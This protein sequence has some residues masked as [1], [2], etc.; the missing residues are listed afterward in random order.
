MCSIE[1]IEFWIVKEVSFGYLY[2]SCN[3]HNLRNLCK[4]ISISKTWILSLS[5]RTIGRDSIL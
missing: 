3:Y 1:V 2:F 4:Y 5:V